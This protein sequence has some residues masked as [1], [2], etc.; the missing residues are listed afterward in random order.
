MRKPL[1]VGWRPVL[2]SSSY[3]R[4]VNGR[5]GVTVFEIEGGW[6]KWVYDGTF[7]DP[8]ESEDD[9]MEAAEEELEL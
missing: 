2:N 1:V 5:K 9:A 4:P 6:W 3:W 7:S 8:F